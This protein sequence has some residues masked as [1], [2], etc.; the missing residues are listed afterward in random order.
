MN[1]VQKVIK[2]LYVTKRNNPDFFSN[3]SS[4]PVDNYNSL[5]YKE[6]KNSTKNEQIFDK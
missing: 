1:L 2:S 4:N 3:N 6:K 5:I